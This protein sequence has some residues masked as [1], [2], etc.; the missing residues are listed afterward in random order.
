MR[1]KPT[2]ILVPGLLCDGALWAAQI[3]ALH[4]IYNVRV[5]DTTGADSMA[6]LAEAALSD[7]PD[8]FAVAGLSMGGYVVQ[9]ILREAP[10]RVSHMALL[11]TNARADLP[12]QS[13]NRKRMMTL[14]KEGGLG[15]V[16]NEMLPHLIH[17]EHLNDPNIAG[18]F[19]QMAERIG[20]EAFVR[21]QMA[22]M[23]RIDGRAHLKR[24]TC[25]VLILCGAQDA[26]TPPKVHQEMADAIGDNATMVVVPDC[27]HLSPIEQPAAVTAALKTWLER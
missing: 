13:D 2:L 17:P 6:G 24:I 14:A 20:A 11:D 21:Q 19:G 27:G 15:K 1:D 12:E 4:T 3:D 8:T 16:V 22:I 5:A 7:A 23:N 10:E 26:M 9:E 25:P 18:V